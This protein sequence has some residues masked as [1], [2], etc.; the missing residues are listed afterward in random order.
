MKR[1][2][3]IFGFSLLALVLTSGVGILAYDII[4]FQ[5]NQKSIRI[6]LNNLDTECAE[7]PSQL[8]ELM[9]AAYSLRRYGR[10]LSELNAWEMAMVVANTFAP[11]Y[12]KN[13]SELHET[14]ARDLIVKAGLEGVQ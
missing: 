8:V 14:K 10:L 9:K 4:W 11:N 6:V 5:P 7:L 2:A 3:K 13:K 1:I 12:Y